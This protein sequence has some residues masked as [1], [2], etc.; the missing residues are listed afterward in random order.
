MEILFQNKTS[1]QLPFAYTQSR[2]K[3]RGRRNPFFFS[4][5]GPSGGQLCYPLHEKDHGTK[6]AL[7]PYRDHVLTMDLGTK[8]RKVMELSGIPARQS[9]SYSEESLPDRFV[10]RFNPSFRRAVLQAHL[11]RSIED[12]REYAWE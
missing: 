10:E 6:S 4:G 2:K 9:I 5:P 8:H 7:F 11:L 12:A 1:N 3:N